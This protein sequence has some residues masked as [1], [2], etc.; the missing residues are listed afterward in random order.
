MNIFEIFCDGKGRI[1]ETNMSSILN[2]MLDPV[3]PHGYGCASLAR[4]L[5]PIKQRLEKFAELESGA[6][7]WPNSSEPNLDK[8]VKRFSRIELTLEEDF[9]GD[10]E[11]VKPRKRILDSV[12]RFYD[13]E[14]VGNSE[15]ERLSWVLAIEN[16]IAMT[17]FTDSEQL[18]EEYTFLRTS[19]D[20]IDKEIP[21]VFIFLTPDPV[22]GT[23]KEIFDSLVMNGRDLAV[24]YIWKDVQGVDSS[25][26]CVARNLLVDER[27]GF[28]N[29]ASSHAE[30]F[31][32]SMIKF[33]SND[34]QI[35]TPFDQPISNDYG[36]LLSSEEEF[37]TR[38]ESEKAGTYQLAKKI[39]KLIDRTLKDYLEEVNLSTK[40]ELKFRPTAT[41][42]AYFF[43]P[44]DYHVD[45]HQ[46]KL[47]NRPVAIFFQG[48][49]SNRRVQIQF[50]RRDGVSLDQ[51]R[52]GLT[53]EALEAFDLIQPLE[54]SSNYTTVIV[55]NNL[56][57]NSVIPLLD[58]ALKESANSAIGVGEKK[59][60]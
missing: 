60:N 46:K 48:A 42:L 41:R 14:V 21:I 59:A 32:R 9:F 39:C 2:F 52:R 36:M 25:I 7:Q 20:K 50:E 33:I 19:V 56:D 3:R 18:S 1:N 4:F 58:A 57:L 6:R 37:W 40:Y 51:F 11:E 31:L 47:P 55:S 34:F 8:W 38:W 5:M 54:S 12:I 23:S 28:I 17:S 24:N 43:Q 22:S 16:K 10:P 13:V 30:L 53:P 44:Y 45:W 35:E 29:P 49:T 26:T 27:S 15:R